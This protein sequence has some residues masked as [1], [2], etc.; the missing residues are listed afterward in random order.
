MTFLKR[1]FFFILVNALII[2]TLVILISIVELYTGWSLGSNYYSMVVLYTIFGMGGAFFSL[3]TSKWMVKNAMG[4]Q[5]I[6]L[7]TTHPTEKWIL[8]SVHEY[9]KKAG[10]KNMPEVG[11]YAANDMNAFATGPSKNNSLVA[12]SS[13]LLESMSK[14]EVEGVIGHE[15]AHIANGDMVTLTLI[16]GI[17]NTISML[18][19]RV[20]SDIIA[21]RTESESGRG[22]SRFM[23]YIAV[24]MVLGFLG[25]IVVN[26][27]SRH[28]EFRADHGGAMYAGREKMIKALQRLQAG[29]GQ[30]LKNQNMHEEPASIAAFKISSPSKG[31]FLKK[32][33]MTHPPLEERIHALKSNSL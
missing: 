9:A 26:W 25:S 23:I 33:F 18:I 19:A 17:I 31:M 21:S 22:A 7:N 11:I 30:M 3:F 6:N 14:D 1:S 16:Q 20:V 5:V 10:L 28:R 15:V 24:S 27:F 2:T 13:G 32:L 12:V 8:N 29:Q 4:V